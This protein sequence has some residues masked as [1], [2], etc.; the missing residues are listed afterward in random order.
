M[1]KN[2]DYYA[3]NLPCNKK[4]PHCLLCSEHFEK[5]YLDENNGK[6]TKRDLDD[7]PKNI[8]IKKFSLRFMI[9]TAILIN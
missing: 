6:W 7:A 9:L 3:V 5:Q 2:V 1:K 8:E 4:K